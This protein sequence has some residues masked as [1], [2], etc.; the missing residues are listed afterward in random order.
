MVNMGIVLR[1]QRGHCDVG[2]SRRETE[3]GEVPRSVEKGKGRDFVQS[4]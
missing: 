1:S 3:E 2:K 4:T